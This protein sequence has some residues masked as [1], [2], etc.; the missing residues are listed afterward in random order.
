MVDSVVGIGSHTY[1]YLTSTQYGGTLGILEYAY[2]SSQ[3]TA[4]SWHA[5]IR[6]NPVCWWADA[7]RIATDIVI[8][9]YV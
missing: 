8:Y 7:F 6:Y 4:S 5:Q 9:I 3:H 1:T 2:M